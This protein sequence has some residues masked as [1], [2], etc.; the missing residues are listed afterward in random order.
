[1]RG[2]IVEANQDVRGTVWFYRTGV[3]Y[4]PSRAVAC[5]HRYCDVTIDAIS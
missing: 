4:H 3:L 5:R 1:M 2:P